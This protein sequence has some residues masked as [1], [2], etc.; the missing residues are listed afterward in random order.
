M[1]TVMR[2]TVRWTAVTSPPARLGDRQPAPK[3]SLT[4][5]YLDSSPLKE[6]DYGCESE[7]F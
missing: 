6:Y 7:R 1:R 3:S 2:G 4:F 5:A